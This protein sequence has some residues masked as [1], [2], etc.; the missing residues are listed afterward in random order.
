MS[1]FGAHQLQG[2]RALRKACSG[3][4]R[5]ALYDAE[6]PMQGECG[7]LVITRVLICFLNKFKHLGSLPSSIDVKYI[8]GRQRSRVPK[9]L[10][11]GGQDRTQMSPV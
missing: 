5:F 11:Q 3:A 6:L 1:S 10:L 4:I 2:S 7:L 8:T 9:N